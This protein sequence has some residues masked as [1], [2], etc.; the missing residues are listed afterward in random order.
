MINKT[1]LLLSFI[2]SI[3][4]SNA[5]I[6]VQW[7]SRFDGT[8]SLIDKVADF[9]LDASGNT[10]VT[11]T[12][13]NGTNF[14]IVTVK[15]DNSGNQLWTNTYGGAGLDEARALTLDNNGDI[16]VT[17]AR[18]IV[19]NDWDIFTLK[20]NGNTGAQIWNQ[21][22]VGSNLYD[23]GHDVAVNA[24]NEIYV[25]GNFNVSATDL[26]YIV[27]KYSSAGA[28][29][30]LQSNGGGNSDEG[31]FI[32]LDASSNVYLGGT[33]EYASAATYYDFR[34][35]KF[36]A[37][38][39]VTWESF[40]DS[41]FNNID[42][43][44]AMTLDA[45]GNIY[46]GGQGFVNTN[47]GDDYLL[48]KFNN[49]GTNQW[50]R[51]YSGDDGTTDKINA[52]VTDPSTGNV[53]VTGK[54]KSVA[55]AEDY[56]TIAYDPNGNTLWTNRFT[57]AGLGLDEATDIEISSANNLYVTGF[58]YAAGSN[59]DYYTIK[60]D[61][62]G[63]ELWSTRFDGPASNNDKAARM[64]IDAGEN[65]YITGSSHGGAATNLDYSTIKYCQLETIAPA[66]VSICVGQ[67]TTLVANSVGNLG[68]NYQWSLVSGEAINAGNFSCTSCTNPTASPSITSTYAVSSIS[69]SGCVDFD[70]VTVSVN[71]IPSPTIYSTSSL[72]FCSGGNVTLYTDSYVSYLWSNSVT[73]SFTTVST[74]GNY[75]VT[76]T[77]INGCQNTAN[78]TVTNFPL[79]I[80]DAGSAQ[81]I[82]PENTAQLQAT[83]ALTYAWDVDPTLSQLL[84][85]NPI[86]SP[87]TQTKYY[88]T[89]KDA[90]NC[91]NIDSVVISLF[92][93]PVVDA[94]SPATICVNDSTQLQAN[95]AISYLWDSQ[96]SMPIQNIDNPWVYPV[97]Q[98]KYIVTGTDA[99]GCTA[100]DSVTISTNNLPFISAGV[101][102]TIC[103]GDSAHIF[104]TG[105]F[106][107]I[108]EADATLSDL[109]SSNPWASSVV[110]TNYVV[111]GQDVNGCKNTDTVTVFVNTFPIVSA[112]PD[113]SLC[114]GSS[115]QLMAS[116]A[117]SYFWT[118]DPTL[119]PNN[120]NNPT[121]DPAVVTTYTVQ[122]T[123]ANGCKATDQVSVTIN[124][125]PIVLAGVD[126][127][128]CEGDSIQLNASGAISYVWS[129]HPTLNQLIGPNPY[130]SPNNLT[131]YTVQGTDVNGCS[132]NASVN[133]GVN[134]NP[135]AP[136]ITQNSGFLISD[137]LTGNQW[138]LNDVLMV[139]ETDDT[140]NYSIHING[141]YTIV[142][143]DA[144]GCSSASD[145]INATITVEDVSI[146][147]NIKE[148]ELTIYPNPTAEVI[149]LKSDQVIESLII[150]DLNGKVVII[151][152]NIDSKVISLN[153][154]ELKKGIYFVKIN[155]NN[156]QSIKKIIKQ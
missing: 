33:R 152:N 82:C 28:Q 88:V 137:S 138:Y 79:P 45:F 76:I 85:D 156:S 114:I 47:E 115:I 94:G 92:G 75:S 99:N 4:V 58:S 128:I 118:A 126:D 66:D 52:I 147:E 40:G 54:S 24:S 7:E 57:T 93:S 18:F 105:A 26:D 96:A 44:N 27:I 142:Y 72:S 110:Q 20:I 5:Q 139:G 124:Q 81:T 39:N 108:W 123:D 103:E 62:N 83:G 102:H 11:G 1:T 80:V 120:V 19:S 133:I 21:V 15:Y 91:T 60:Y 112:G 140:L 13:Y 111:E 50:T 71:T 155:A 87:T 34:V 43:P 61:L 46:I 78:T 121:V 90:N 49:T 73:D 16:I 134:P 131:T 70:T 148:L 74:A 125:L 35:M 150:T 89:G 30:A 29:L 149:N 153:L 109:N 95:G 116:G 8:G 53:F 22:Y 145:A 36:D 86:A 113:T 6:N 119:T 51:M 68:S 117:V 143:T 3:L 42:K 69:G 23:I 127:F 12:S 10:F 14:D 136:S 32:E 132:N 146:E 106:S 104:A 84:I 25:A 37:N 154:Y 130:A 144:N 63:N 100:R 17:G 107:Y 41:G 59:N 48:M 122:G 97:T 2:F 101:D 67:S 135:L 129:F 38:L 56:F 65:V 9:E 77:D 151:Q 31:L 141:N 55:S 64:K 98:T